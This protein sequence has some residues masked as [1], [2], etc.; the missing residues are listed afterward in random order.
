LGWET[1]SHFAIW[2][3]ALAVALLIVVFCA[4][5]I[6]A[7]CEDILDRRARAASRPNEK[8]PAAFQPPGQDRRGGDDGGEGQRG[9]GASLD[10]AIGIA[11]TALTISEQSGTRGS[12][13]VISL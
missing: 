11:G 12:C 5:G 9:G 13:F 2:I 4:A 3:A 1:A 7:L 10:G 8:S 6:V